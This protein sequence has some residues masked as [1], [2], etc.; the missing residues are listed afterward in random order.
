M[1]HI[2]LSNVRRIQRIHLKSKKPP[3][4]A[5]ITNLKLVSKLINLVKMR[6]NI[7]PITRI[8][9]VRMRNHQVFERSNRDYGF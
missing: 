1:S 4:L 3:F 5:K 9:K 2:Y 8:N 7:V 6:R